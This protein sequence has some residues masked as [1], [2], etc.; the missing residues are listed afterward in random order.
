ML[1]N[2]K[3]TWLKFRDSQPNT[4]YNAGCLMTED[5]WEERFVQTLIKEV[6]V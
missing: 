3:Q 6:Q 2:L 4:L 1:N 5:G